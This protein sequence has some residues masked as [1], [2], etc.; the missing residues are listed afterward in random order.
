MSLADARVGAGVA[1][2]HVA[3]LRASP[4]STTAFFFD[5]RL[6]SVSYLN[7][8]AAADQVLVYNANF[9]VRGLQAVAVTIHWS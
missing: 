4:V 1:C 9:S 8:L 7:A 6:T 5:C 2:A 3:L